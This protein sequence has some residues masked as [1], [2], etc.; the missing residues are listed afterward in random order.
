MGAGREVLSA[1]IARRCRWRLETD[2]PWRPELTHPKSRSQSSKPIRGVT[3]GWRAACG[4]GQFR[5]AGWVSPRPALSLGVP[6]HL[7]Q[8]PFRP[9]FGR[10]GETPAA[11]GAR[12]S[13]RAMNASVA[14][15]RLCRRYGGGDRRSARRQSLGVPAHLR[16]PP[17]RPPFGRRGET[18]AAAG[19]R[20]SK[21]AMNKPVAQLRLCR[22]HGSREG[23]SLRGYRSASLLT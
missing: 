18:P 4:P 11:A 17:F 16:Q 3:S 2:P 7:K 13:K 8:P 1:A 9:P 5:P 23:G 19:T 15:L 14:Q 21:R 12:A 6:A 20:A 10:R 22:R